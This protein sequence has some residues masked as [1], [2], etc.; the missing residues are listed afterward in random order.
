MTTWSA[1]AHSCSRTW[2]KTLRRPVILTFSFVQPLLWMLF[3]GFLFQRYPLF[4]MPGFA[5]LDYLAPGI[6]AMTV[7]FVASQSGIGLIRVIQT[8]CLGRL[9]N[10]PTHPMW[11]LGGKLLADVLRLLAQ[12]AGVLALAAILG[13]RLHPR[14]SALPTALIALGL[15]ATAFASL[16]CCIA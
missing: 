4:D 6:S 14:P 13:A 2:L 10:T 7:L 12:A 15:F 9:L 3:F 5:Y 16:S 8:G 11:I 1:L